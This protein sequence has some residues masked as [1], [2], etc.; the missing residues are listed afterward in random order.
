[1]SFSFGLIIVA[2]TSP[3]VGKMTDVLGPR[4]V[5]FAGTLVLSTGIALLATMT[6]QWQLFAYYG[7]ASVGFSMSSSVPVSAMI[8]KWFPENKGLINGIVFSGVGTGG[9]LIGFWSGQLI[10]GVGW[11]STLNLLALWIFLVQF[12]VVFLGIK[13]PTLSLKSK[14]TTNLKA[15]SDKI[16][17][18]GLTLKESV[19]SYEFW[20][21]AMLLFSALASST[22]TFSQIQPFL[23]D[24]GYSLS[25]ANLF[26]SLNGL[27]A[28]VAKFTYSF[29]SDRFSVK[30]I[31]IYS[32]WA[33]LI[34]P[35]LMVGV[36]EYDF[37]R[38]LALVVPI[39]LGSSGTAFSALIAII[40]AAAFGRKQIGAIT[41]SLGFALLLGMAIGPG[42]VGLL[43]ETTSGYLIPIT[44]L[45]LFN[46][47][48]IILF[49]LF[50]KVEYRS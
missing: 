49:L 6:N 33:A 50:T 37:P 45:I 35:L 44:G 39:I 8:V 26:V 2:I 18:D 34:G 16:S 4:K 21:I 24:V 40:S 3:F 23:L 41:G 7:L 36:T 13:N 28:V 25:T 17:D 32:S 20:I 22:A 14:K 10:A 47:L 43:F 42:F 27:A 9:F 46:V 15:A 12:P 11:V 38:Y 29:L 30:K 48:F 19:R 5:V 31:L 1:M